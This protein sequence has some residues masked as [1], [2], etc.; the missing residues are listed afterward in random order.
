MVN[1]YIEDVKKLFKYKGF[2]NVLIIGGLLG[3]GLVFCIS[4]VFVLDVNIINVLFESILCGSKIGF[5]GY[6]NNL[7]F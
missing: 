7:F 2:K 1:N 3:Y 5:V 6:W 4:L